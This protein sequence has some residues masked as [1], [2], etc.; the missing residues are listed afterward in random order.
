MVVIAVA[1]G[2]WQARRAEEK[3]AVQQRRDELA[4]QAVREL[5][6]EPFKAEDYAHHRVSVRGEF[7]A[8]HTLLLDNRVMRGTVGYEVLAP[9]RIA[10][11]ELHVVVN[12]GWIAAGA[13]RAE[14]PAIRTPQ[15][16]SR[17]EGIALAPAKSYYALGSDSDAGPVVQNL[18][19]DRIGERTGLNLQPVVVYQTSDNGDGLVRAW[20][21][22]DTGINTHRGYAL[23]WY[24]LAVLAL[25]LYV[26]HSVRRIR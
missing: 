22:P 4:R 7:V 17:L 24:L 10:G 26:S 5:P 20:A 11:G 19:L 2:L 18:V 9:F 16:E 15:G 12:R 13:R 21:R 23:Q 8:R 6:A 14:L 25:V 3:L 1:L